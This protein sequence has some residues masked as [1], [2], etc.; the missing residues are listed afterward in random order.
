MIAR[1][2]V[3]HETSVIFLMVSSVQE[4]FRAKFV[5]LLGTGSLV[6]GI[7]IFMSLFLVSV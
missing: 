3:P 5:D 1:T 4:I 7:C 2:K 6:M